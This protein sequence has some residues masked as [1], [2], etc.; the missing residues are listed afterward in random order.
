MEQDNFNPSALLFV[1]SKVDKIPEE[2]REDVLSDIRKS[3]KAFLG[4]EPA[5][6]PLNIAGAFQTLS[7]MDV[8]TPDLRKFNSHLAAFLA[9]S[10]RYVKTW[11]I[12]G[13]R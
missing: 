5:M 8:H 2:E 12:K 9:D 3:L 13:V 7:E 6:L 11:S 1:C 4:M 10:F